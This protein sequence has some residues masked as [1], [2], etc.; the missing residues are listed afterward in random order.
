MSQETAETL[1]KAKA[2]IDAPEKFMQ[3]GGYIAVGGV[4]L[5][6]DS[7]AVPETFDCACSVGAVAMVIGGRIDDCFD[8]DAILALCSATGTDD[9]GGLVDWSDTH[10]H[11]DVMA[12][13]DRA[14]ATES[15]T[16][17]AGAE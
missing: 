12:A 8:T 13:F 15:A 6:A 11:A 10:E 9:V 2:L 5:V 16:T 14:I 17:A 3:N 7:D 4:Q 1:R